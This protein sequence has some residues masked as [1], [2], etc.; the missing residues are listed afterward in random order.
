MVVSTEVGV[1][2][3]KTR[4]FF[5]V[6]AFYLQWEGALRPE[7]N[8]IYFRFSLT[9]N[10]IRNLRP[11]RSGQRS[12]TLSRGRLTVTRITNM[13]QTVHFSSSRIWVI[14]WDVSV[15][16]FW[17][18]FLPLTTR[19]TVAWGSR[20]VRCDIRHSWRS[21]WIMEVYAPLETRQDT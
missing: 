3:R 12:R 13:I 7:G 16:W 14:R 5:S 20:F 8:S 19:W 9:G 18:C 21:C 15:R 2:G 1:T 6:S 4:L 10:Y 11:C 17:C